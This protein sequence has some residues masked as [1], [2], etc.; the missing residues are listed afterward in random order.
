MIETLLFW[1]FAVVAVGS[2]AAMVCLRSP[3]SGALALAVSFLATA[4]LFSLLAGSFV[5]IMQVLVYAGAIVVLVVF[6]IMLLGADQPHLQR[7]RI[8]G[9][10]FALGA[11]LGLP[12]VTI[13]SVGLLQASSTV[14]ASG[15]DTLPEG[16]GGVESF[17]RLFFTEYMYPFEIVSLLLLVAMVAV[18][19]LAKREF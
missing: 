7:E 8:G 14:E 16:F 2:A 12:L 6:V 10:R 17:G 11:L 9:L 1:T 13:L 19:V 3:L 15:R 4:G 18:V 5:A